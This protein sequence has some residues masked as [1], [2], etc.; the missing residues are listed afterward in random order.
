MALQRI[1]WTQIDTET[2]TP[3][4]TIDLGSST[5]PLNA[6]YADNLYVSGTSLT[7]LTTGSSGTSGSSG[8]SGTSGSS[9]SS[10]SSGARG[11]SGTSGT[12][13]SSGLTGSSG[14]SGTSGSSGISGTSGS[15]GSSGSSGT[16]GISGNHGSSGSSGTS[17]A[18]GTSGTSGTSG[19]VYQTSSTT[20]ITDIDEYDGE[21][22][23][24]TVDS[25]LSYTTGQLVIAASNILNYLIGRVVSYSGTQL[26]IRILE[27]VGGSD[28]NSWSINLYSS[29]SGGEGGG[30]TT[31][32]VGDGSTL[33]NGVDQITFDGATVTDNGAGNV[34]VT[35]VGGGGGGTD[36]TSGS[37]G[38]SGTSGTSGIAGTNGSSGTA[39]TSGTSGLTGTSG[40]SGSSGTSGATGTSGTSGSSGVGAAGA[41]L[42]Y[43]ITLNTT[44]GNI[45]TAG[46]PIAN[47][48]GPN[49]ENKTTLEGLGWVFSCPSNSRLT[50]TRPGSKQVQP[51]VN[52]MVHGNTNGNVVSIP[53]VGRS[54]IPQTNTVS[55]IQTL[56]T[57]NWT[58]LDLYGLVY[59]RAIYSSSAQSTCI[60]TFGLIS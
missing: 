17:G 42:M 14:T 56:S 8:L 37:N 24:F 30:T 59:D 39:G 53:P 28:H 7:D 35:I 10:G 26:V 45:D 25:N 32:K 16:S 38:S 48:L 40:T 22:L 23:T 33:V 52:I 1:N 44:G 60:I 9:G 36:G 46:T 21:D 20:Y 31:L 15:N 43:Q 3:G 27:H 4:T 54:T 50:I 57:S 18:R 19:N 29:I 11:T 41:A 51:L 13:G 58:T 47:V 5:T 2:V 55:A 12:S 34:T 49:G 6:V